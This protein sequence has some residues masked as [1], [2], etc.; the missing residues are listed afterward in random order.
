MWVLE[1]EYSDGCFYEM[2]FFGM[3]KIEYFLR[4]TYRVFRNLKES[5]ESVEID[6]EGADISH[7]NYMVWVI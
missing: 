7:F 3:Y 6:S 2:D 4:A 5:G 1:C